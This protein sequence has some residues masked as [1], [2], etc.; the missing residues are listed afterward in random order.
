MKKRNLQNGSKSTNHNE[1]R[2]LL[3]SLNSVY[4]FSG[5]ARDAQRFGSGTNQKL[6]SDWCPRA[7]GPG[8]NGASSVDNFVVLDIQQ[9]SKNHI[10][11]SLQRK[12]GPFI[13]STDKLL[14]PCSSS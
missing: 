12:Q 5:T 9:N 8:V 7:R 4:L 10:C 2:D 13:L 3:T 6:C 14:Y 11:C 1:K